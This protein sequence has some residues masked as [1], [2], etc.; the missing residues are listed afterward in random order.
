MTKKKIISF[1]SGLLLS[2]LWQG[3]LPPGSGFSLGRGTGR[4]RDK[5]LQSLH[6]SKQPQVS[7]TLLIVGLGRVGKRYVQPLHHDLNSGQAL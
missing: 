4:R 1:V 6:S 2:I 3:G 7:S 5:R